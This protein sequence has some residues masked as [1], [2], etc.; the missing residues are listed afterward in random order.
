[1]NAKSTERR[2][3]K[4]GAVA[5]ALVAVLLGSTGCMGHSTPTCGPCGTY[6]MGGV[7]LDKTPGLISNR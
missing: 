7:S 1:M 6:G 3:L 5:A 4:A 2:M